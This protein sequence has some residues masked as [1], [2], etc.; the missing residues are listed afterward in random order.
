MGTFSVPLKIG[1]ILEGNGFKEA[2]ALVD[3]GAT[4]SIMPAAVLKEMGVEPDTEKLVR[5]ANGEQKRWLSADMWFIYG[6][7]RRA[8]HVLFGPEDQ[9][10]MGATTL[11]NFGL[12]VDTEG[13][14]LVPAV[15]LGRP[16]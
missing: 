12:V 4:H 11:E 16:Y 14:E 9:Y 1:N 8:C 2:D 3:T 7:E 6:D 5:F 15:Y 10:V 13:R